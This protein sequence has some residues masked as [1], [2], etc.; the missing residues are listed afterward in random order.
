MMT[1]AFTLAV[2]ERAIKTFAQ[3]LVAL[4]G[5]T[6]FDLIHAAWVDALSI[7]GGA[8]VLSI[9]TSIASYPIGNASPSLATETIATPSGD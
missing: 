1:R 3:T 4:F 2:L 7:A 5:A 9:L 6:Q 8:A